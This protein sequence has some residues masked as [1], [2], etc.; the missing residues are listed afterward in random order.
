[1]KAIC[2]QVIMRKNDKIW[3]QNWTKNLS[4]EWAS[5]KSWQDYFDIFIASHTRWCDWSSRKK[6]TFYLSS[7]GLSPITWARERNAKR[8]KESSDKNCQNPERT[9]WRKHFLFV[10]NVWSI[11]CAS[12]TW[13]AKHIVRTFCWCY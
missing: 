3:R 6:L 9:C 4:T 12:S 1:M 8:E 5:E 2:Y 13:G 11:K 7:K 10:R